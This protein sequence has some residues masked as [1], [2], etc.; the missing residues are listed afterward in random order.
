MFNLAFKNLK[1]NRTIAIVVTIALCSVMLFLGSIYNHIV[2][3][4]FLKSRQVVAENVDIIMESSSESSSNFIATTPLTNVSHMMEFY[5]GVLDLYGSSIINGSTH[6]INLKGIKEENIFK[7]NDIEYIHSLDRDLKSDEIVIS[8]SASLDLKLVLNS[9]IT[10]KIGDKSKIFYVGRIAKDHPSFNISGAYVMYGLENY[11][12]EYIFGGGFGNIYNKIYIKAADNIE[13]DALISELKDM[14]SYRNINVTKEY[15]ISSIKNISYEISLPVLISIYGCVLLALYLLYLII[16]A[17]M[18]K[19]EGLIAQ[20]KSVGADNSYIIKTFLIEYVV[21]TAMGLL[22]G[23]ALSIIILKKI[24]PNMIGIDINDIFYAHRL[25]LALIISA[26]V[27][28]ILS[29]F[30]IVKVSRVSIRKTMVSSKNTL[31]KNNLFTFVCGI[32]LFIISVVL[33][34]NPYLNGGRGFII[35]VFSFIGALFII[36]YILQLV[37]ALLL[38]KFNRGALGEGVR[39]LKREKSIAVNLRI[40]YAG[41]IICSVIA[42]AASLT[43]TVGKQLINDIDS[44]II[45]RN[46]KGDTKTQLDIINGVYGVYDVYAYQYHMTTITFDEKNLNLHIIGVNPDDMNMLKDLVFVTEETV[47]KQALNGNDGIA[48]D[49]MFHKIHRINIGDEIEITINNITH[50]LKVVGFYSSYQYGGRTATI[51]N[52]YFSTLYSVNPYNTIM[53]KTSEDVDKT[54]SVLR[55]ELGFYNL[56]VLNKY[57][58]FEIYDT[59]MDNTVTFAYYFTFFILLVSFVSIITNVINSREERKIPR[60]QM[61]SLG[62][63]RAHLMLIETAE[64]LISGIVGVISA[65]I[66]SI[67]INIAITNILSISNVYLLNA[68]SLNVLFIMSSAFLFAYTIIALTSYYSISSDKLI[69]ALKSYAY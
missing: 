6:Y 44:D 5:V 40:F 18:K 20:L 22:L 39:N 17:G 12:S 13:V 28:L 63:S 10:I 25:Y 2:E 53:C 30:P 56:V 61:F 66:T 26:S 46:V 59:I 4:E 62:F 35:L 11:V 16:T 34:F 49:Y 43:V 42:S 9:R 45:I 8:E 54:V 48:L 65:L 31:W 27:V 14:A 52:S 41:L 58:V 67:L 55:N 21:Y 24:L 15:D 60:Y 37:S 69:S 19:R 23:G 57:T 36:P 32:T 47:L 38:K 1:N 29:L 64:N 7:L 3:G 33:C 50:S 51:S 68:L